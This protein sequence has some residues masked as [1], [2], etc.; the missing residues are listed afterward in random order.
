[1]SKCVHTA[2]ER[3][4]INLYTTEHR[5]IDY[6][7][8]RQELELFILMATLEQ[9]VQQREFSHWLRAHTLYN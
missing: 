9:W 4:C 1:M 7:L 3:E 2:F 5:L 6:L 8:Q